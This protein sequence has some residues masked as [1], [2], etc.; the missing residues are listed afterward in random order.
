MPPAELWPPDIPG[1]E[2][3][4]S[5]WGEVDLRFAPPFR[6]PPDLLVMHSAARANWVA[7]YLS[8]P[9]CH[10]DHVP[11]AGDATKATDGCR[12]VDGHWYR[13][14]A[15]HICWYDGREDKLRPGVRAPSAPGFV[16]TASLTRSVPGAG[17]SVCQGRG[18]VN[19]RAI[20]IELPAARAV[21]EELGP[22]LVALVEAVPSLRW[23]TTHKEIRPGKSDPV[24]GSGFSARWMDWARLQWAGRM[25]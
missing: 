23:W 9:R 14:A 11:T 8:N 15:A 20:H 7:E 22:V 18:G 24:R 4:P 3:L 6:E 17:G 2:W 13:V 10:A 12:L 1:M 16:M 5:L 25:G 19:A 21:R